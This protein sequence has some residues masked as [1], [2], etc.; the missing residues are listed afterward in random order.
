TAPYTLSLHD[1]LPISLK[2][3]NRF[4]AWSAT[5][6]WP[7]CW[8]QA[9]ARVCAVSACPAEARLVAPAPKLVPPEARKAR[10][11][12]VAARSSRSRARSEEHTSELQSRGH[13]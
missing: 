3:R 8:S 7:F 10:L 6:C 9:F 1:A 4:C 13:L 11:E 5:W 2:P 12:A